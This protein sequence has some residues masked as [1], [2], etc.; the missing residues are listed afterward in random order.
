M[1]QLYQAE[2]CPFSSLVRERCTELGVA[3][4]ARQ[5]PVRHP[6]RTELLRV[7]GGDEIPAMVL[8][9]GT[10]LTGSDTL[11]AWLDANFDEVPDAALHR[12]QYALEGPGAR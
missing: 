11:L 8:D 10:V 7:T 12:R 3:F 9:D 4:V 1:I 2:W 6:D 5:V